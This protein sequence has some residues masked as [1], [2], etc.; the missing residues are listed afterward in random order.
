MN[1]LRIAT[2]I[3]GFRRRERLANV[4][5]AALDAGQ[6]NVLLSVD[7]P[8]SPKDVPDCDAVAKYASALQER[9]QVHSIVHKVNLGCGIHIERAISAALREYDAVIVL[10]DDCIPSAHF[11]SFCKEMLL[12]YQDD[13]RIFHV[14]GNQFFENLV[15]A[16]SLP[17][18]CKYPHAWGWA[19]WRRAWQHYTRDPGALSSPETEWA[20]DAQCALEQERRY[21]REIVAELIPGRPDIWDYYWMLSIWRQNGLSIL[22]PVNLVRNVGFDD[23][24]THTLGSGH[25]LSLPVASSLQELSAPRVMTRHLP[26]ETATFL[27]NLYPGDPPDRRA[28]WRR[29]LRRT[30]E[31]VV[32]LERRVN[33]CTAVESKARH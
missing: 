14:S 30:R 31:A 3:V 8:R 19:T 29:I 32:C 13:T 4:V 11:F 20:I 33:S 23:K 17:V 1:Q 6:S 7:G 25:A 2:L 28:L 15:P 12:R 26:L 5:D 18:F 22:P 9:G 21:W 24:A 16:K 10:E 27:N